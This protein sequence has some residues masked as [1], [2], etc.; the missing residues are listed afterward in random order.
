M[1]YQMG[2]M[3]NLTILSKFK[4]PNLPPMWNGLFTLIFKSFS[5]RIIGSDSES[6]LFYNILYGLYYEINLDYGSILWAQLVQS[7]VS[8]TRHSEISCTRFWSL[9]V[10]RAITHFNIPMIEGFIIPAILILH[11]SNFLIVDPKK[12]TFIG[13]IPEVMLNYAPADNT[14]INEY[15]SSLAFG[16]RPLSPET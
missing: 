13:S 8:S 15:R 3:G 7:T 16:S 2:Y 4:K 14:M 10:Q 5:D 12:F 11:T 6:K 1:F 9:I